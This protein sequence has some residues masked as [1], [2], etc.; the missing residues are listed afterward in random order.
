MLRNLLTTIIVW[1]YDTY[2]KFVSIPDH[3]VYSSCIEYFTDNNKEYTQV[4]DIWSNEVEKWDGSFSEHYMDLTGIDYRKTTVPEHV[5]KTIVRVKYWYNDKLYKYLTYNMNHEWPPHNKSGIVFNIP[6]ISAEIL[7]QDDKPVKDILKKVK[8]YAGPRGDFHGERVKI[9]D[10][11]YYDM[12]T[13]KSEYPKIKLKNALGK[14]KIL[15]THGDYI[16]DLRVF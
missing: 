10:M 3:S 12:E 16:T 11:L 9:S 1:V 6:L 8:R 2:K 7:D 4:D 13:L 15:S 5:K 14:V